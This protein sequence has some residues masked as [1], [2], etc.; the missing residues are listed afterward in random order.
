MLVVNTACFI[1]QVRSCQITL[2]PTC[3]KNSSHT[4]HRDE[5]GLVTELTHLAKEKIHPDTMTADDHQIRKL[6]GI[7]KQLDFHL[8]TRFDHFRFFF[9]FHETVCPRE[10][11]HRARTF[12]GGI[13]CFTLW[14]VGQMNQVEFGTSFIGL[15][16]EGNLGLESGIF[17][18]RKTRHFPQNRGDEAGESENRRRRKTR[19]DGSRGSFQHSQTEGFAG[20]KGNSVH[21]NSGILEL[22]KDPVILV[23]FSFRRS[24]GEQQHVGFQ[25]SSNHL[26]QLF[27]VIP[28]DSQKFHLTA[29]FLCRVS[30]NQAIGVINTSKLHGF[31]GSNQFVSRRNHRYF[32]FF[33]NPDMGFTNGCKGSCFTETQQISTAQYY[34]PGT[35]IGSCE[36]DSSSW[37]DRL[38]NTDPVSV[39]MGILDHHHTIRSTRKYPSG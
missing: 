9:D 15:N 38:Q 24:S 2:S 28:D 12:T 32:G 29:Q 6:N 18:G 31:S 23:T 16:F 5:S 10:P 8:L 22:C 25:A 13:G 35:Q 19:K 39:W 21:E 33:P 34:F 27:L 1:H 17:L 20:L 26:L 11:C 4:A 36:G 14:T 30:D 3:G 37:N 7:A